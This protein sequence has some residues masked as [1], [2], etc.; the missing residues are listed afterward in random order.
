M[1]WGTHEWFNGIISDYNAVS[2][3]HC[4]LYDFNTEQE[5]FEWYKVCLSCL[6]QLPVD[7]CT[8]RNLS[9]SLSLDLCQNWICWVCHI[10]RMLCMCYAC[11]LL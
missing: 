2:G 11:V 1:Q 4:I 5:T 8:L 3:E 10:C 6:S 9:R 7:F